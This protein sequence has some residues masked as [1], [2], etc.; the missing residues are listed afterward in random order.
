MHDPF[1]LFL[2]I[3]VLESLEEG[4]QE[5]QKG[6]KRAIN[7]TDASITWKGN[8]K[9]MKKIIAACVTAFI[10]C[11]TVCASEQFDEWNS[12]AP[13]L[14]TLI[15]YVETVT[16]PSYE[17]DDEMLE[18]GRLLRDHMLDGDA[19]AKQERH[20]CVFPEEMK[21]AYEMGKALV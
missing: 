9:A 17:P 1:C 14:C 10:V 4:S 13:A 5:F 7:P 19:K 2:R 6:Y 8:R 16:D 15:G 11:C 18:Y 20:D 12:D 21:K 3:S